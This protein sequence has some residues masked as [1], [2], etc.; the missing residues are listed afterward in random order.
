MLKLQ[1][2]TLTRHT[3]TR[4]RG[5]L[6]A[7]LGTVLELGEIGIRLYESRNLGKR[8]DIKDQLLHSSVQQRVRVDLRAKD[9][10]G[11][12][13]TSLGGWGKLLW[14]ADAQVEI[15]G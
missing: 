4:S 11:G 6:W 13:P 14:E 12:C 1:Q 7:K 8:L 3:R 15:E 9:G 5:V 10:G 2:K